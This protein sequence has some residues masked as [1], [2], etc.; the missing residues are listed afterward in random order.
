MTTTPLE[1][2]LIALTVVFGVWGI[3]QAGGML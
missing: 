3:L 2:A 1:A